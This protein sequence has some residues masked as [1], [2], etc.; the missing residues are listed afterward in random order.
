MYSTVSASGTIV[1]TSSGWLS[2]TVNGPV[3]VALPVHGPLSTSAD[4]GPARADIDS[5]VM[6]PSTMRV[7]TG[8]LR[9][10]IGPSSRTIIDGDIAVVLMCGSATLTLMP[11]PHDTP[12]P[13]WVPDQRTIDEANLTAAMRANGFADFG[14]LYRWSIDRPGEFWQFVIDELDIDF[15]RPPSGIMGSDDPADP[16]WLP[17]AVFNI[18]ASCL[19]HDPDSPA[20][21]M[22]TV[23]G[24]ETVTVADLRSRI[25]GFAAGCAAAGFTIGDA[26]A[27]M[28][29]M[30]IEAVVAYLGIIAAGGVVVSIADSFAPDE[31]AT[32]M[33]IASTVAVVTQTRAMRAGKELPMYSK[34]VEAGPTPCIVVDAGGVAELRD[35]DTMWKDFVVDGTAFDPV[36]LPAS[37]H[38][39]ILFSSGTTGDPKAIP[40]TQTPPI[41]AAMDGRFHQDIHG[42]DVV[43]WPTNLGW[44]MGPW[45]IYASLLNGAAMALYDDA[46]TGRGF[47]E[48][49]A[50]A[51]VTMLGVVP[52]IVAAWRSTGVL[53]PGDWTAVRV[54]SSTGEASNPDDYRWLIDTA[55][56]VP[57]IEYCGGTEI[58]GGYITG[59][60]LDPCVPSRF[61]TPALGLD[62]VLI[63]DG[64]VGDSGEVFL[65]PPSIG[66]SRELLNRDHHDVYFRGVP[67]I[68]RPLRRHGDHMERDP[69][70]YY[71]ALGRVDDTMNLGGIKVSSA[72]L[73]QTVGDIEGVAE[74]AAVAVPPPGGGPERLVVFVTA[75]PGVSLDTTEL[76]ATM[77]QAVRSRLNPLFKVHEVVVIDALP[78]TASNKVMRRLL[79]SRYAASGGV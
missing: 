79:R 21:V 44:M 28:M 43:A 9:R 38:T 73:E 46:P 36:P 45:L 2:V 68:G 13:A 15:V 61:S 47:I 70:G 26:I 40:W 56:G 58:G 14:E 41:K 7:A 42:G 64:V 48:F 72:D 60:V 12:I 27:I 35:Q 62:V 1:T 32:R 8:L 16:Q 74:C 63:N 29:P 50:D 39:N 54:I 18:V 78:R 77:Q 57:V 76:R 17:G 49:V 52:S 19:D 51:G 67:Q 20:I 66:L 69:A 65:V 53:K 3:N 37:A 75:V 25:A 31:I 71:R 10:V 6:V 22:G 30:N 59:T 5:I 55:G 34:C 11:T 23:S 24:I 33:T 4:A